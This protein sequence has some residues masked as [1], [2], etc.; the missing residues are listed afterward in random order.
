MAVLRNLKA[1][2]ALELAR[3][4]EENAALKAATASLPIKVSA[5]GGVSV[6]GLGRWPVTLYQSQWESLLAS[7][8][9]ILAFIEANKSRLAS[10]G[11]ADENL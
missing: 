4:R 6:Y 11:D 9:S 10:K 2:E 8:E 5:K 3:L 7:K 1:D